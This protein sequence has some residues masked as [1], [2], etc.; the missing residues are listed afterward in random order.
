MN[1]AVDLILNYLSKPTCS[2]L[3]SDKP[4]L[5]LPSGKQKYTFARLTLKNLNSANNALKVDHIL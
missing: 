2:Q 3:A 5:K 4:T 1:P